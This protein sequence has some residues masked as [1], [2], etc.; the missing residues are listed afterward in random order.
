[1]GNQAISNAVQ[2]TSNALGRGDQE[3]LCQVEVWHIRLSDQ[4]Q[5]EKKD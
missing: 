5:R 2:K 4:W 1:M 3:E